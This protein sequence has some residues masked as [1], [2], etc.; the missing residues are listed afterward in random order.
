MFVLWVLFE[1]KL[2]KRK[3]IKTI[4]IIAIIR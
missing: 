1:P 2:L 4:T 3:K